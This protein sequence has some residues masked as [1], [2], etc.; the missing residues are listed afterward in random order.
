MKQVTAKAA[1]PI[2]LAWSC[3]YCSTSCMQS[4]CC[5]RS[6]TVR[7]P[8][9][10]TCSTCYPVCN[11]SSVHLA[12]QAAG[13]RHQL[14]LVTGVE[15]LVVLPHLPGLAHLHS[16]VVICYNIA[17]AEYQVCVEAAALEAG[18]GEVPGPR[19]PALPAAGLVVPDVGQHLSL[20]GVPHL[21][22]SQ[23]NHVIFCS[24]CSRNM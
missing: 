15:H 9:T 23:N 10:H 21:L 4:P 5:T 20:D 2:I 11:I 3:T 6:T 1:P 19:H 17:T 14:V 22:H 13:G 16:T 7:F 12:R 24:T 8:S 18:L